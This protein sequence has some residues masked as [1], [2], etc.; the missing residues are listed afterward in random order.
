MMLD[1]HLATPVCCFH[2]VLVF[3]LCPNI[4]VLESKR[5][6]SPGACQSVQ[7]LSPQHL[8]LRHCLHCQGLASEVARML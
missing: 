4:R 3:C 1:L 2:L 7:P 8:Q 6:K 5:S